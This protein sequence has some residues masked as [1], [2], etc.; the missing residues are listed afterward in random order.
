[1]APPK[2]AK[3]VRPDYI[4]R[5]ENNYRAKNFYFNVRIP[6]DMKD[7][8]EQAAEGN[9]AGYVFRLII[10]DMKERGIIE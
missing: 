7:K 3:S 1:M 5:A 9:K 6:L 4:V 10:R 2:K 8:L